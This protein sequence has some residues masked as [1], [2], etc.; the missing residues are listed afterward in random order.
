MT[1]TESSLP[2]RPAFLHGASKRLLIGGEWVEA[3]DGRTL[4]TLNPADGAILTE[5][6]AG[7]AADIDRAV[8]AARAAFEGPW[9]RWKPFERQRVITRLAELVEQNYDELS[10]L[11]TLDMGIP[12]SRWRVSRRAV[13]QL[14]WYAAQ[15]VTLHGQTVP[16]SAPGEF[17]TW[18]LREPV[19]VV[20]AITPWNGPISAAIW[21][22]GPVLATGCTVVLKPAEESP[23]SAL[24]LGELCLEAGIPEGV[25]NIVTGTGEEAGAALAAHPD[26][27][28]I[29]F[30][31]S[32]ETGQHIVRASAG[33]MKR[34]TLELGG[35]S[36]NIV[37]ADA[38]LDAA[39]AGSAMAVFTNTG[40]VCSAG[41]RLFVE[42]AVFDRVVEGVAA[43]AANLR[44]GP[45]IEPDTEMGPLV[46]Q[47]QLDRV[48]GYM[49][50]GQEEGAELATGGS[51]LTQAG[52]ERGY[53]VEPTVLTNI[54]NTARI[55]QE[56]IFGP[57]L[58]A[59]PFIEVSEVAR[60]ANATRYGLASAVWTNNVARA[61][62]LAG[63]IRAGTVWLNTYLMMDPAL[64]F[65]G[66]KQSGYG[67]ESGTDQMAEYLQT[68]SVWLKTD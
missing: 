56:E 39:I 31:G 12:W 52:C 14:Y 18:T 47:R 7:S 10:M 11:D 43:I 9:S 17:Q 66:Y 45:G 33:N 2:T 60:L 26:V 25:I 29:A 15:A 53:F 65:G 34:L 64:P 37:F 30:T 58:T 62:S 40:Q 27:D 3:T 61:H 67:R 32:F 6:A 54:N 42:Q 1:T 16:N 19:G 48:L 50:I 35:K 20:G 36:P 68:K 4:S 57:V 24:R 13:A 21:K 49:A 51:R 63:L 41:T 44:I 22:I 8:A 5:V 55:A 46:S 28:K 59:I 23:L 38:D